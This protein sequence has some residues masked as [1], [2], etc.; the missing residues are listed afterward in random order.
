MFAKKSVK[1]SFWT[2]IILVNDL[3]IFPDSPTLFEAVKAAKVPRFD[4]Q[5][6]AAFVNQNV[7][8][9]LASDLEKY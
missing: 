5:N 7:D 4:H 6:Q 1:A 9:H 8:L 3:D 2:C